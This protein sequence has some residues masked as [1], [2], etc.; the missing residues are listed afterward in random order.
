MLRYLI[1][2]VCLLLV[3]QQPL[4]V[5]VNNTTHK[6][7][8]PQL[9]FQQRAALLVNAMSVDEK[10]AQLSHASPAIPRL[11]LPEYNWWNEALHGIAPS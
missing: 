9:D 6:W 7:F 5:E 1:L 3:A 2:N 8:D 4:A 11:Q 10:I